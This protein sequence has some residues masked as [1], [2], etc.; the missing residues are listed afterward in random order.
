MPRRVILVPATSFSSLTTSLQ[1]F[2]WS[3]SRYERQS[4]AP[5]DITWVALV[6]LW[7]LHSRFLFL[8]VFYAGTVL[9]IILFFF[10]GNQQHRR[11]LQSFAIFTPSSEWTG[12]SAFLLVSV[13]EQGRFIMALDMLNPVISTMAGGYENGNGAAREINHRVLCLLSLVGS[14]VVNGGRV[15]LLFTL[16]SDGIELMSLCL[17]LHLLIILYCR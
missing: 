13:I 10:C 2:D 6:R 11:H 3:L 14:V 9:S 16:K 5:D 15:M 4:L 7:E 8:S 17:A 1:H 12:E